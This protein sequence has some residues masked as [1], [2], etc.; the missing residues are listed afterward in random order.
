MLTDVNE[1]VALRRQAALFL[2]ALAL[3]G[4]KHNNKANQP[5]AH[6]NTIITWQKTYHE[7]FTPKERCLSAPFERTFTVSDSS[8]GHRMVIQ[9]DSPRIVDMGYQIIINGKENHTSTISTRP[10]SDKTTTIP[11]NDYCDSSP[12]TITNAKVEAAEDPPKDS[13]KTPSKTTSSKKSKEPKGGAPVVASVA[14][15]PSEPPTAEL[16]VLPN[17]SDYGRQPYNVSMELNFVRTIES[18]DIKCHSAKGRAGDELVYTWGDDVLKAGDKVT[19]R[20]Y[21]TTGTRDMENAIFGIAFY[22]VVPK[23]PANEYQAYLDASFEKDLASAKANESE[24]LARYEEYKKNP[25][26]DPI[27]APLPP[28][29]K[30]EIPSNSPGKGA[31][32]IPGSWRWT[33]T[34]YAWDIGFWRV[35]EPVVVVEKSKEPE[36]AQEYKA[37]QESKKPQ[38]SKVPQESKAPQESYPQAAPPKAAPPEA[39]IEQ[40]PPPTQPNVVWVPGYWMWNGSGYAWVAGQWET[41]PQPELRW[42]PP[43][44]EVSVGVHVFVPGKW[45]APKK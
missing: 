25:N 6:Q 19:V 4:C 37:P 12:G 22:D 18:P 40:C 11:P 35:P 7:A 33:G 24:C 28:A 23:I 36:I 27:R 10:F 5:E 9:V 3:L 26:P 29:P 15:V 41:P 2:A 21:R 31:K 42:A 32:W 13:S 45:V 16:V 14:P 1:S 8:F 39:K 44:W 20:F 34:E 30:K 17:P 38:E 43:S